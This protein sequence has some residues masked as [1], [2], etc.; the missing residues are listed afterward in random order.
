MIY[1]LCHD[2]ILIRKE[3]LLVS[4]M[5][6]RTTEKNYLRKTPPCQPINHKA[7]VKIYFNACKN[8]V[9][10]QIKVIFFLFFNR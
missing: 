5:H 6:E 1:I 9:I 10:V 8:S 7:I 4:K 2:Q 3:Y